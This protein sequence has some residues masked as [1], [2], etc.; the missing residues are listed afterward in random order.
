MNRCSMM[1][2]IILSLLV[3]CAAAAYIERKDTV[4][5]GKDNT[6]YMI[7]WVSDRLNRAKV[8]PPENE[9]R[10]YQIDLRDNSKTIFY[11]ADKKPMDR[12]TLS[13]DNNYIAVTRG[14]TYPM[15]EILIIDKKLRTRKIAINV[16]K[17]I[18]T[19]VWSPDSKKIA[20]MTGFRD[21][22][23]MGQII[24]TGIWVYDLEKGEKTKIAD[25]ARDIEWLPNGAFCLYVEYEEPKGSAIKAY[26]TIIYNTANGAIQ[27]EK[28]GINMSL[29]G[30]YSV[31]PLYIGY[32]PMTKEAEESTHTDFYD[33][34]EGRKIL[35]AS[36]NKIYTELPTI[37]WREILWLKGNRMVVE[38][39]IKNSL[40]WDISVCDLEHNK[41]L[42][43]VRGQIIGVNSDR[44]KIVLF[45]EGKF[46]VVDVP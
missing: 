10:I 19:Y 42:K 13:P 36:L 31:D 46:S 30:K 16:D 37:L 8:R 43:E 15:T 9:F 29:D 4:L 40:A 33:L 45:Y 1:I 18:L 34:K 6:V 22:A 21:Q 3:P 41:V 27:E 20:Y 5:S 38:K 28:K 25:T 32:T 12:L 26:K 23:E 17:G 7:G 44:S 35:S 14:E 24:S 11:E 2:M 39:T